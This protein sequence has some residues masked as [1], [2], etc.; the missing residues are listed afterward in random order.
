MLEIGKPILKQCIECT[1]LFD[2][3]Y[4]GL[5]VM[6][7]NQQ[8][9]DGEYSYNKQ[10]PTMKVYLC[11]SCLD[12]VNSNEE[13]D[14][15][16]RLKIISQTFRDLLEVCQDCKAPTEN[17]IIYVCIKHRTALKEEI[18]RQYQT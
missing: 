12:K 8:D 18:K 11:E 14:W 15:K 5:H 9:V 2:W 16:P 13:S 7:L 10:I 4:V 3:R 1:E 17:V 6:A